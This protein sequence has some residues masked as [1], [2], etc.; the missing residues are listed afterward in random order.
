MYGEDFLHLKKQLRETTQKMRLQ[1]TF[2]LREF[3]EAASIAVEMDNRIPLFLTDIQHLLMYSQLG[4]HAPYT[5]A[6]WCQLEKFTKLIHTNL[7]IIEN[8]SAYDYLSNENSFQFLSNNT[9]YKLEIVNPNTYKTD[10]VKNLLMVPLT[11][12]ED[13]SYLFYFSH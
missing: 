4:P 13:L 2:R 9:Q 5:P 12:K 10:S 6:R 3:G 7:L 8:L 1:P 11:S